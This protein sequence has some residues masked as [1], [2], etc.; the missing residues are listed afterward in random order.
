MDY[1]PQAGS[2]AEK[3]VAAADAPPATLAP[4]AAAA[5]L[6]LSVNF[7]RPEFLLPVCLRSSAARTHLAALSMLADQPLD[8]AARSPYNP[9]AT[10]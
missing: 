4:L 6:V 3:L 1:A 7:S 9:T 10:S 8:F 2:G 5:P